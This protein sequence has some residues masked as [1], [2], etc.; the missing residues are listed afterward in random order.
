MNRPSPALQSPEHPG[1]VCPVS[2]RW[3][4]VQMMSFP[5]ASSPAWWQSC[6]A[7][8]A[9]A[10]PAL[11]EPPLGHPWQHRSTQH[12]IC[13]MLSCTAA[14][15]PRSPCPLCVR[16]L[17]HASQAYQ[18]PLQLLTQ[19]QLSSGLLFFA[20]IRGLS[21]SRDVVWAGGAGKGLMPWQH[22]DVPSAC[23]PPPLW[24]GTALR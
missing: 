7:L 22:G 18:E 3:R 17:L 19:Q 15:R 12:R 8:P 4:V 1:D 5:P 24:P 6:A 20:G 23:L 21:D 16:H 10:C 14:G 13:I 11:E 2:E 9:V